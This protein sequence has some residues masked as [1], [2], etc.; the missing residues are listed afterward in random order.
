[1]SITLGTMKAGYVYEL[2]L[3]DLTTA[4]GRPLDNKLIC[5]TLNN[6]IP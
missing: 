3:G 4:K 2:K 5:Y 1:M 6:L